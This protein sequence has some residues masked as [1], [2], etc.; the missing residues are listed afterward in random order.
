MKTF[1]LL[2]WTL[3]LTV[4]L[5]GLFG[6]HLLAGN[7]VNGLIGLTIGGLLWLHFIVFLIT[8]LEKKFDRWIQHQKDVASVELINEYLDYLGNNIPEVMNQ[9]IEDMGGTERSDYRNTTVDGAIRGEY[10]HFIKEWGDR[11]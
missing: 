1:R 11:S 7:D 8:K 10:K 2:T 4:F 5:F 3:F 6:L 9:D